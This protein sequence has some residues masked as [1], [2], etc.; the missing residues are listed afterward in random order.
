MISFVHCKKV[1]I[2]AKKKSSYLHADKYFCRHLIIGN[3]YIYTISSLN[4]RLLYKP[5]TC[6]LI[7]YQFL[8][9]PIMKFIEGQVKLM[10]CC[11]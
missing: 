2:N 11:D 5:K 7:R 10:N 9:K 3:V 4:M 6:S 8:I 1:F